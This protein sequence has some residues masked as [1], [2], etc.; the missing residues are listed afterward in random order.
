MRTL[1]IIG[2]ILLLNVVFYLIGSFIAFD[3]NPIHWWLFDTMIGRCFFLVI[4]TIL[5]VASLE[6]SDI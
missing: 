2:V 5:F 1:K 6:I 4:E 3:L